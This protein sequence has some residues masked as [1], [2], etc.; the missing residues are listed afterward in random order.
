MSADPRDDFSSFT[1]A[2]HMLFGL[3]DP[4]ALIRTEI[5]AGMTRQVPSTQVE[6]I[7]CEG[8]P[9]FLTIG[10]RREDE[11]G[12]VIVTH[13][14]NC[15]R[16]TIDVVFDQRSEQ[17]TATVTICFGEID[18]PG[19]ERMRSFIDLHGD[20]GPAF[21]DAVFQERFLEFREAG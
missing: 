9:K 12:K 6:S 2:E 10:R 21:A 7:R 13:F 14:G 4:F 11:P 18:Q 8:E 16:C 5:E 1:G 15:F 19:K 3:D 20:A 17:L